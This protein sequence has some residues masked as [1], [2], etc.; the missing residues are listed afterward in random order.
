MNTFSG[1]QPMGSPLVLVRYY[2]VEEP[3]KVHY[4]HNIWGSRV[5]NDSCFQSPP[6]IDGHNPP[7]LGG[8]GY[9]DYGCESKY[10]DDDDYLMGFEPINLCLSRTGIECQ[11]H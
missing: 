8:E 10:W 5:N 11:S 1:C 4:S 6:Y 9:S 2:I 3:F 7:S